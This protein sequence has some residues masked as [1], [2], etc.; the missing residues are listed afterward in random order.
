MWPLGS[1][2]G[3]WLAAP[4]ALFPCGWL[5]I[6]NLRAPLRSH[7]GL[8]FKAALPLLG[9]HPL[10]GDLSGNPRK[11]WDPL[12]LKMHGLPSVTLGGLWAWVWALS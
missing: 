3:Q 12:P 6:Q 9:T 10:T 4:K 8:L 7:R 2:W 11:A 1:L 5:P